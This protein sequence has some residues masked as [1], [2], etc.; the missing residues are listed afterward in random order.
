[1][2]TVLPTILSVILVVLGV[3]TLGVGRAI[4]GVKYE[5][6][7]GEFSKKSTQPKAWKHAHKLIGDGFIVTGLGIVLI[8]LI[9]LAGGLVLVLILCGITF[10]GGTT[11]LAMAMSRGHTHVKENQRRRH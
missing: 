1:M 6:D 5:L 7:F 11:A 9:S 10:I 8:G 2:Q 4:R 3:A